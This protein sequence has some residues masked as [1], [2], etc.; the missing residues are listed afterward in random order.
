MKFVFEINNEDLTF[1]G[2]C[3]NFDKFYEKLKEK[4]AFK[5]NP[6]DIFWETYQTQKKFLKI[7]MEKEAFKEEQKKIEMER[8]RKRKEEKL[9]IQKEEKEMEKERQRRLKLQEI[10]KQLDEEEKRK[11]EKQ[12]KEEEKEE[13]RKYLEQINKRRLEQEKEE[14]EIRMRMEEQKRKLEE[15]EKINH[16]YNLKIKEINNYFANLKFYEYIIPKEQYNFQLNICTDQ[17]FLKDEYENNL[18]N[19]YE[20]KIEEKKKNG[21]NKLKELNGKLEFKLM[22]C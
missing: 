17:I 18:A 7:N 3:E 13:R 11:R 2:S 15:K 12:R 21:R 5:I 14:N 20:R 8:E 19:H 22:A 16:L 1:Y 10:E 6:K 9:R 4:K